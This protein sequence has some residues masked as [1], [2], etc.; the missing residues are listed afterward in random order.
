MSVPL[1]CLHCRCYFPDIMTSSSA[2]PFIYCATFSLKLTKRW[3]T[4]SRGV[5]SR[6]TCYVCQL[7][8]CF[9]GTFVL[10][11]GVRLTPWLC[12]WDMKFE[13]LQ[14]VSINWFI[15]VPWSSL[16][17]TGR[18]IAAKIGPTPSRAM[19]ASDT[20]GARIRIPRA[21]LWTI[22]TSRSRNRCD[23]WITTNP[24]ESEATMTSHWC[25]TYDVTVPIRQR[26]DAGSRGTGLI[27]PTAIQA[28]PHLQ[29]LQ[30]Q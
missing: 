30:P 10:S 9:M 4:A 23:F 16:L 1:V 25:A 28:A 13:C 22:T 2:R 11:Q 5:L 20:K 12:I 26:S 18:W 27:I 7:C 14:P 3:Q 8:I 24:R 17:F 29:C 6:P 15:S 21:E 19:K